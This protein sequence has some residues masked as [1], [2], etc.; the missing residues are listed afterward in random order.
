MHVG[1][2][3]MIVDYYQGL[4]NENLIKVLSDDIDVLKRSITFVAG[5]IRRF[6]RQLD[7]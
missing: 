1:G 2:L 7:Q 4:D 6:I 3:V 5:E